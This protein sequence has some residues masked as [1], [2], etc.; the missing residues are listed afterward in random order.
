MAAHVFDAT[1]PSFTSTTD[2]AYGAPE[3]VVGDAP[4]FAARPAVFERIQGGKR[5]GASPLIFIAVGAVALGGLAFAISQQNRHATTAV[6]HQSS[7]APVQTAAPVQPAPLPVKRLSRS[8]SSD[9]TTPVQRTPAPNHL[10]IVSA[11]AR[12]AARMA[13]RPT[14]ARLASAPRI[15]EPAPALAVT[16]PTAMAVAPA[17]QAAAPAPSA[18]TPAPLTVAPAPAPEAPAP[19]G[20]VTPQ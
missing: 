20:D 7:A 17:P 18:S 10:R 16:A 4:M 1:E 9:A 13:V 12:P 6:A 3:T 8:A 5:T 2:R 11:P 15:N 14:R 19:S